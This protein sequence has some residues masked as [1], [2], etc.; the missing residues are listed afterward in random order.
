MLTV[1]PLIPRELCFVE[2]YQQ[3][4]IMC[5]EES[6]HYVVL[7][8][9]GLS[10]LT[11]QCDHSGTLN[12]NI[13]FFITVS[14]II[15]IIHQLTLLFLSSEPSLMERFYFCV[16][17][18]KYLFDFSNIKQLYWF[19][20]LQINISSIVWCYQWYQFIKEVLLSTLT[21]LYLFKEMI[22]LILT[23]IYHLISTK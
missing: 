19:Q 6:K 9:S 14:V 3:L 11:V 7:S 5:G 13:I 1:W 16:K 12:I 18:D 22:N 17:S 21:C 15:L 10:F 20:M 2:L 23:Y 8:G 4:V